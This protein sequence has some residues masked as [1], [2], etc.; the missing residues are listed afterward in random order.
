MSELRSRKNNLPIRRGVIL[1]AGPDNPYHP[2][3]WHF[4]VVN[5][6]AGWCLDPNNNVCSMSRDEMESMW[7]G[8]W[9]SLPH[10]DWWADCRNGLDDTELYMSGICAGCEDERFGEDE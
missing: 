7:V 3:H 5:P 9:R 1:I 8:E 2:G 6:D 4:Y 10:E